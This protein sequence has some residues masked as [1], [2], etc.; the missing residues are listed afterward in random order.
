[1]VTEIGNLKNIVNKYSNKFF[2]VI[3]CSG[4]NHDLYSK[5]TLTH[6]H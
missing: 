3:D 2:R 1:M 4:R 5:I 6:A